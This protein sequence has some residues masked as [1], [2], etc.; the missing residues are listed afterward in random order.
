MRSPATK[1]HSALLSGSV[2]TLIHQPCR[3]AALRC[4]QSESMLWTTPMHT[5]SNPAH[6]CIFFIV[7]SFSLRLSP[8]HDK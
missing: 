3:A 7:V 6:F 1:N 2:S 5:K 4:A 8:H